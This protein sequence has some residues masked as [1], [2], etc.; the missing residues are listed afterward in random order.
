MEKY[1]VSKE[2]IKA[3]VDDLLNEKEEANVRKNIEA[4][5]GQATNTVDNLTAELATKNAEL[6]AASEAAADSESKIKELTTELEAAKVALTTKDEELASVKTEIE[7]M[8]K[9]RAAELRIAELKDAGV[10]NTNHET[11][12]AKVREMSDEEF[13]SYKD[14]LISIRAAVV[15]ELEKARAAEVEAN[16][17]AEEEA[18]LAAEAAKKAAAEAVAYANS[19]TDDKGEETGTPPANIT[20]GQAAMASLNMEY[21]PS[22]DITK[23]FQELGRSLAKRMLK[24][25]D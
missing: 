25:E 10:A 18:K 14:E 17:K 12:S 1:E 11:Q 23:K 9:D 22:A 3:L 6:V 7:E 24:K 15:A 2:Q 8:K 13:A 20:P 19:N 5:L 4:A 16:A 21:I